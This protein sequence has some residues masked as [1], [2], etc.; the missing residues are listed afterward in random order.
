M[1]SIP[2]ITGF[3]VM[4]P[5]VIVVNN[6]REKSFINPTLGAIPFKRFCLSFKT[7]ILFVRFKKVFNLLF[8]AFLCL[9]NFKV[10]AFDVVGNEPAPTSKEAYSETKDKTSTNLPAIRDNKI[11]ELHKWF[12]TFVFVFGFGLG[13]WSAFLL[14]KKLSNKSIGG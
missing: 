1:N 9:F 4:L 13:F 5:S 11:Q 12:Y 10:L 14:Y 7:A 3:A 8:F 6:N 2:T